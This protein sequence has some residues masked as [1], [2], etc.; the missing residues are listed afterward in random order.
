MKDWQ[1]FAFGLV[2]FASAPVSLIRY[3]VE[4][5]TPTPGQLA[6]S[7]VGSQVVAYGMQRAGLMKANEALMLYRLHSLG[8]VEG[9]A[10]RTGYSFPR[11]KKVS[12]V[13]NL[14]GLGVGWR[15][16][17]TMRMAAPLMAAGFVGM[18]A[19]SLRTD[20][21]AYGSGYQYH[22]GQ[23]QPDYTQYV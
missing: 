12:G 23:Y 13:R 22:R 4:D 11:G 10:G 20:T 7:A 15:P 5:H 3:M 9:G 16:T 1:W 19:N 21:P 8:F 17:F 14:R 6:A 2:P 18:I